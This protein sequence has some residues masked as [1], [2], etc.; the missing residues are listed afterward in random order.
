M[1]VIGLPHHAPVPME[2][3][4]A[5]DPHDP[6]VARLAAAG[7]RLRP[8]G[9]LSRDGEAYR[10]Y[11]RASAGE[12]SAAKE[13]NVALRSGWFSDRTATYLAAGRPAV[14][15]DTGFTRAIPTGRGLFAYSTQDDA[16]AALSTIDA[17][18]RSHS[19]AALDLAREHLRAEH[20][21]GQLIGGL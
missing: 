21:L 8:A 7:W 9:P 19:A 6:D 17:D 18:Y 20:V 10:R 1:R 13:Q 4:L 16:A 3:A 12:F 14:V 2:L 15:Q 11:I 5:H